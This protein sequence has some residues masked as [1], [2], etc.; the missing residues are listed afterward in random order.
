MGA[1]GIFLRSSSFGG[2]IK[3]QISFSLKFEYDPISGF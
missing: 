3:Y 1:G 2:F